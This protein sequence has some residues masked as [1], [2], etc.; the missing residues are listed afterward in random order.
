MKLPIKFKL[1]QNVDRII[2]K[3]NDLFDNFI[4]EIKCELGIIKEID[5]FK[6]FKFEKMNNIKTLNNNQGSIYCLKTLDDGRLA[7]GDYYSNLI[8]YNKETF[9]PE[10][11]IK[12]NLSYLWNFTQ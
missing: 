3:N 10:I 11:T 4:N 8:I 7:A 9:N 5:H 6:N 1:N 2:E 12:N